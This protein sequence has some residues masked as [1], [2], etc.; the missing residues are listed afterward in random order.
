[1]SY[2]GAFTFSGGFDTPD[3]DP[4]MVYYNATIINNRTDV[5]PVDGKDPQIRFQE[6][7]ALPIIKDASKYHFSIVRFTMNGPNKDLPLF[8][9]TIRTGASNPTNNVNLTTYSITLTAINVAGGTTYTSGP[10]PIVYEPETLDPNIAPAPLPSSI[11]DG[12]QDLTTRYYW[13]YTYGHWLDLV[14]KTF[15]KAWNAVK[16]QFPGAVS[17]APYMVYDPTTNLFSLLT[18]SQGFGKDRTNVGERWEVYFNSDMMGLFTNFNNYY[19]NGDPT[20]VP[21][22]T[23]NYGPVVVGSSLTTPLPEATNLIVIQNLANQNVVNVAFPGASPSY[24]FKTTQTCES[25]SSIWSP[26]E[27]IVF[28]SALLPLVFEATGDPVY[29][30]QSNLGLE[31]QNTQAAF[32]PIIT[33]IALALNNACNYR[34]FIEYAP[35]AEYRL[36]SFQRSRQPINN[37]DIQV[38]WKNRLDGQLYP[39]NMFNASSVSLKILFRRRGFFDYP[40]PSKSGADV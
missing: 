34:E 25:T 28:T 16:A 24:W 35:T 17:K 9:P 12:T 40:H 11:L 8:I 1:M 38:F 4:D 30:G 23:G 26:I 33:D 7:R 29:F 14:N 37:I 22:G 31:Q 36:A 21:S 10:T 2:T 3:N 27:S 18:D 20:L 19:V 39:V 13:V 5:A 6:T 32:Q 15:T